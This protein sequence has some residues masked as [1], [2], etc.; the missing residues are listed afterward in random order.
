MAI[1]VAPTAGMIAA[2]K[3]EFV[4]QFGGAAPPTTEDAIATAIANVIAVAI[5]QALTEIKT[6]ADLV[7]VDA[8]VDTVVGGVD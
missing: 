1:T 2:I 6:N 5:T 3:A 8:G 7:G 4:T